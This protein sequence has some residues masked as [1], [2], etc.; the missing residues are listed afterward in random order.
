MKIKGDE[1][2]EIGTVISRNETPNPF[3]AYFVVTNNIVHA[4]Q[5]VE[6]EVEQGKL[7]GLITNVFKTNKYFERADSV[8]EFEAKGS[9]LLEQFPVSEWEYL[10]A[11][12]RILGI[13]TK[14]GTTKRNSFPVSPG[15][16]VRI[17]DNET[18]K[19][20]FKF[21]LEHG[22]N[23]GKIEFHDLDVK[24]QMTNLLQKHL[25]ILGMSGF[26][27]S[28]SVSV[29]IEELLE[30]KKN[31]G[32]IGVIVF[33]PHGEYSSFAEK[34]KNNAVDYS[35]N[36]LLIKGKN[37]RIGTPKI[38]VKML[39]AIIPGITSVQRRE[40]KRILNTL[41]AQMKEGLGPFDLK[42]LMNA[43]SEDEKI[44]TQT[45]QVLL[46][47]LSDLESMHLFSKIDNPSVLDI[48][49]PGILTVIDLSDIIDMR[50]K[51]IIVSYYAK[52]VFDARR[53][54]KIPPFLLVLEEAHQFAPQYSTEETSV[55]KYIIETIAREGRK[56]GASLC[57]VSQRPVKLDT[58]TLS[59]C[60]TQIILRITNPNDLKHLSE[61]SEAL[62]ARSLDLIT[63]L[64]V[65]EALLLGEAVRFPLFFKVRKRKSLPSKH[66]ITLEEAAI[67]FE[68]NKE[69][70]EKE[71]EGFI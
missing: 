47:W 12:T 23:L 57:L 65:G 46:S 30:R 21:D 6:F 17:A 20:F 34:P 52:K 70:K 9:A 33:D 45:Q 2:N 64:Q 69:E 5:F 62:D 39:S 60:G 8:K 59:Q 58:T 68:Q 51:Q 25:A 22:L 37:I 19:K 54:K 15:T 40:L 24:I 56:F 35:N 71:I 53:N 36:T 27:K 38:D 18:L 7:I 48:V 61:S 11:E 3:N 43:I 32:R 4:S 1:M 44:N 28:F 16:K 55:S 31:A 14:D 10:L 26:G 66:E 42:K 13:L 67:L 49:K 29:L 41:N 63:S 50:K